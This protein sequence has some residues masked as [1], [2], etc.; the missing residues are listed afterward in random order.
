MAEP[1]PLQD[2]LRN[3]LNAL[4]ILQSANEND[5]D[6]FRKALEVLSQRDMVQAS[7]DESKSI[8][9]VQLINLSD[10]DKCLKDQRSKI[11]NVLDLAYWRSF[12]QSS[13]TAWWWH[14]EPAALF[15]WLEKKHPWLNRLDWLWTF[16]SLF[17]LTISITF[18]FNTL[19]HILE[20]GVNE[21]GTFAVILQALLTIGG[22]TVALTRRG[23]AVLESILILWRIPKHYWHEFSTITALVLLLLV[24]GIHE[25]YL[26]KLA[27]ELNLQGIER[28]KQGQLESALAKYQ[29]AT[30]LLPDYKDAHYNLGVLYESLQRLDE[31]ITEY[32]LVVQ[33][34]P[35]SLDLLLRLRA[36]NNL[37]R[38]YILKKKYRA[39]WSPLEEGLSL[40]TDSALEKREIQAEKYNLLKNLGWLWLEQKQLIE[41]DEVLQEAIDLN[42]GRSVAHCLRAQVQAGLKDDEAAQEHWGKCLRGDRRIQPEEVEWAAMARQHLANT[43]PLIDAE[44]SF[45]N[46]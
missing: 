40:I 25:L 14:L 36:H 5:P 43:T 9:A 18:V 12:T 42:H 38:L 1:V 29:Q 32:A 35:D 8:S 27:H 2:A 17:F 28:Y 41:A 3:Y 46:E 31:A 39:A 30:T 45:R 23:R 15:S 4:N 6:V 37:G 20:G 13:E 10:L 26:P 21:R 22:G 33:S 19:S 24:V 11:L 34:D 16:L 7:L 44:S